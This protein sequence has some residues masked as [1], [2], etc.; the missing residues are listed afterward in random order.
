L[1]TMNAERTALVSDAQVT[2][3]AEFVANNTVAFDSDAMLARIEAQS[4]CAERCPA[5]AIATALLG[6]SIFGNM[7]LTGFAW[8]KGLIPLDRGAILRAIELNGASVEANKRAFAIGREAAVDLPLIMAKIAP[9]PKLSQTLDEL[10]SIRVRQLTAYQDEAYAGRYRAFVERVRSRERAISSSSET[11]TEAVAR[12]LYKLMAIKDEYEVA[13]L[14]AD[15]EFAKQLKDQ[16]DGNFK[17]AMHLAPPLLARRNP[18]SGVPEKMTFG[19]WMLKAMG[20]LAKG[21][22]LRGTRLDIFGRAAERK[23][24]RALLKDYEERIERLLPEL[25]SEN[26]ALAT[27]YASVPDL[28]RGFGHVKAANMKKAEAKYAELE[29]SLAAPPLLKA[30]E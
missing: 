9:A 29:A 17:I 8:Q 27:V 25:A 24:E 4:K 26:L 14:Y 13:R 15:G 5:Q 22:R 12:N 6:D 21:K 1:P 19:P 28:V 23:A 18:V 30:A 11:L 3:T 16:F 20:L 2:P 7:V 10:V